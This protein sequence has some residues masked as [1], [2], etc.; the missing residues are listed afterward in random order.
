MLFGQL[1]GMVEW[2]SAE[3]SWKVKAAHK[4]AAA[5]GEAHRS[6]PRGFGF[7][8]N[9]KHKPGDPRYSP[10]VI[11]EREAEY[12]REVTRRL[13]AKDSLSKCAA[14]L[15]AEG[16]KTTGNGDAAPAEWNGQTLSQMLRAPRLAGLRQHGGDILP[17]DWEAI[18]TEATWFA[19]L[20]ELDS[21]IKTGNGR[22]V[23]AHLLTG[24]IKCGRCGCNL[25]AMHFRQANGKIFDRY[26]C[27]AGPGLKSCGR[28]AVSK[29]SV[30]EYVIGAWL[31][32]MSAA[33]LQPVDT[34]DRRD[35]T[36]E[37][38][39]VTA[40]LA[41]IAR[42]HYV[43]GRM[44]DDVFGPLHDELSLKLTELHSTQAARQLS[45]GDRAGILQ[46]GNRQDMEAWWNAASL[47]ERRVAMRRVY[48]SIELLAAKHR[49]GRNFD[50]DRL[51]LHGSNKF[52][53]LAFE[54][55]TLPDGT[56]IDE[57]GNLYDLSFIGPAAGTVQT[58]S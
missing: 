17:G 48:G 49:G 14:W 21:R 26:Q 25:K 45:A 57:A 13:L 32:A 28:M 9:L 55:G 56:A 15:N 27:R 1:A 34:D 18:L 24:L 2:Q 8:K 39:A 23:Q 50:A 10:P 11:D 6:G 43:L 35:L 46:P 58:A 42:D 29:R 36:A 19:L 41:K 37:I 22:A 40:Q 12:I 47:D 54:A 38:A 52:Y 31:D 33:Y 5:R 4:Q 7:Q 51:V 20:A 16:V 53:T 3:T 44:P 30:D